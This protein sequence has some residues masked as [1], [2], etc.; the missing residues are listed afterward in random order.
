MKPGGRITVV[1]WMIVFFCTFG[2]N[3]NSKDMKTKLSPI[4]DDMRGKLG[5]VVASKGTGG[6]YFRSR[7]IPMNPKTVDQVAARNKL[8][9]YS[10]AWAGLTANQRT[11]WNDAVSLWQSTGIFG[12]KVT[13]SGFNLYV[14]LNVNLAI[15]SGVAIDVPPA[16]P[17]VPA[18]SSLSGTQAAGGATILTFAPDPFTAGSRLIVMGTAPMSQG[19]SSAGSK[20]RIVKICANAVD[21]PLTIT[22]D[23]AAKFGG[24]GLAGQKV[25]F[26]VFAIEFLTGKSGAPL[27][28]EVIVS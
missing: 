14:K 15:V 22:A 8:T 16:I 3:F 5:G 17:A 6:T 25:F 23:Y 18:C 19:R 28:C 9:T 24:P 2:T 12:N 13:P 11:Q 20:Y 7:V 21:S 4:I 1:N 27:E 10:Q 26:K